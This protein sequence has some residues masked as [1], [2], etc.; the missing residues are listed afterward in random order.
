M[1]MARD[2]NSV[3]IKPFQKS[4]VETDVELIAQTM[5]SMQEQL[6]TMEKFV[7]RR[8]DEISMEINAT[9]QQLD[10]AE[11]GLENRFSEILSSMSAISF[12]G[13]GLTAANTGVELQAVIADTEEAAN[14][15]LDAADRMS[16]RLLDE[17]QFADEKAR[18]EFVLSMGSDI[19]D[20]LMACS[21]QDLAGQRIRKTLES[22]QIIEEQISTTLGELG[23]EV[24]NDPLAGGVRDSTE[25]HA[26][27]QADIDALF[28]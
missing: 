13:N 28:S 6:I 11:S 24:K 8:F 16:N 4:S 5:N 17:S 14:R 23:I 7:R 22:L 26:H 27:S 1:S 25:N 21:F 15:I 19:Q 10:M 20:I 2:L 3:D 9:S 12:S 18:S